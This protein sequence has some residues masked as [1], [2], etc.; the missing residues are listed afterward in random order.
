MTLHHSYLPRRMILAKHRY[1]PRSPFFEVHRYH[2]VR[3]HPHV[4]P[5]PNEIHNSMDAPWSSYRPFLFGF[6]K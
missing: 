3:S 1:L 5:E 2:Q 6:L 4:V